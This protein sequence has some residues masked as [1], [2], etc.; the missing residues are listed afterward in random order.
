[1]KTA[2]MAALLLLAASSLFAQNPFDGKWTLNQ[3]KSNMTGHTMKI[4][5]AGNG[6]I[7]FVDPNYTITVKTD[8]TKTPTP[9]GG[10]MAMTK[11]GADTYH[12]TDWMKGKEVSQSDWTLSSG[13]KTL[14]IHEYGTNPNGEKFD[15]HNT[16]TRAAAGNGL[17]GDW[18]TT[19]VKMA[20]PQWFTMRLAGNEL[21]WDIPAIKAQLKVA[22]DG[23]EAHPVGPTVPDDLT[24]A[25]TRK[26]TNTLDITEKMK[27]KTLF[28]G[29]YTVSKN[30]KTM[31]VE[32]KD[33]KGE[34]TKQV[35]E[36]Q[37]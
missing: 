9:D 8:G 19:A 30:G 22:T 32:G 25:V 33:A 13:G 37:G 6:A 17:A 24:L 3:Q 27:G 15:N 18:K 20:N 28:T 36:K 35:W 34:P 14:T 29:T 1:M 2:R 7:K 4:E 16:Y 11:K 21:T 10:S 26:G 23:K 5:D 12:E 31:T